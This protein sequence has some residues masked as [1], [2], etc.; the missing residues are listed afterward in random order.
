MEAPENDAD[1]TTGKINLSQESASNMTQQ[2]VNRA[3]SSVG[4][5]LG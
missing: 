5:R 2:S 4:W 3:K 1:D